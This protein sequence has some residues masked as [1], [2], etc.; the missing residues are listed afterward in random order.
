[1]MLDES[2]PKGLK[3]RRP[4]WCVTQGAQ[5]GPGVH[6]SRVSQRMSEG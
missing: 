2:N 5:A 4:G 1:M 6:K 3:E